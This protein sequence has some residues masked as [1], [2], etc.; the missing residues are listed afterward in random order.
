ME[1]LCLDEVSLIATFL[2]LKSFIN[3]CRTCR[4]NFE[5]SQ[6]SEAWKFICKD[7]LHGFSPLE[8]LERIPHKQKLRYWFSRESR[9]EL[10]V[11]GCCRLFQPRYIHRACRRRC[12]LTKQMDSYIFGGEYKADQMIV[13]RLDLW[14]V[15]VSETSAE[16]NF[17]SQRLIEKNTFSSN[18]VNKGGSASAICSLRGDLYFFGGMNSSRTFSNQ[19]TRLQAISDQPNSWMVNLACKDNTRVNSPAARWGHTMINAYDDFLVLFGGSCPGTNFGDLWIFKS[20]EQG[21]IEVKVPVSWPKPCGRSGHGASVVGEYMYVIGGN[22]VEG[23]FNDMWTLSLITLFDMLQSS[24]SDD[25]VLGDDP[26]V[27][28]QCCSVDCSRED[29]PTAR[30]G[31]TCT[32]VGSTLVLYGG[33][34]FHKNVFFPGVHIY[35]TISRKWS[36]CHRTFRLPRV[37]G[38]D[39]MRTGH[40]ALPVSSGLLFVGGFTAAHAVTNNVMHLNLLG[41]FPGDH[42]PS[43]DY[44]EE[45]FYQINEV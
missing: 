32:A 29:G 13:N 45:S 20:P 26:A 2:D 23:N 33:R 40:C 16:I 15:Q 5:L 17:V 39:F 35:D 6:S 8:T 27:L 43:A 3:F 12:P 37:N 41:T 44:C 34:D 14:K 31:H 21:W 28:W 19:L 30:I 7:V 42:S 25:F 1:K 38:R 18:P 24:S 22:N 10:S 36:R 9:A 4:S 11:I